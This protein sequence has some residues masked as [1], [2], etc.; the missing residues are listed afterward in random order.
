M[1]F[2]PLRGVVQFLIYE[3][4]MV[5]GMNTCRFF[6]RVDHPWGGRL[7]GRTIS[8][9]EEFIQV[10]FYWLSKVETRIVFDSIF[11]CI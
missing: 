4:R 10:L 3:A 5:Q 2:Q 9:S 7:A 1:R 6:F 11:Y 8:A